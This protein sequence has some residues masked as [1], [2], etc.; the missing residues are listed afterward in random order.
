MAYTGD[1]TGS[2]TDRV[3]LTIGDTDIHEELLTDE[4]YSF[5]LVQNSDNENATALAAL[6][7]IVARFASSVT[8]K[9]GEVFSTGNLEKAQVKDKE[10]DLNLAFTIGQHLAGA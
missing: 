5:L 2:A 1:P 4:I 6:Q 7:Y 8:E 3:R 10:N 9:V